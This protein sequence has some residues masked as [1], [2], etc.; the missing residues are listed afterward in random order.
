MCSAWR[1]DFLSFLKEMG[2]C[3]VGH[4][5]DR[6]NP[7]GDYAP[8]NCRWVPKGEQA[9]NRRV[10]VSY[11]LGNTKIYN[12]DLSKYGMNPNDFYVLRRYLGKEKAKELIVNKLKEK[13]NGL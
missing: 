13:L 10:V 8:K 7:D 11:V 9:K 3:P 1:N 6:I 12:F 2:E 4:S 5:L